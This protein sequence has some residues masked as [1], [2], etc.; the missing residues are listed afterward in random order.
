MVKKKNVQNKKTRTETKVEKNKFDIINYKKNYKKL[1]IISIIIFLVAIISIVQTVREESTPIYRD[2]TLKGGLSAIINVD[3]QISVADL[4]D[5]LSTNFKDN[6]FSISELYDE[7]KREGFIIDTD[8]SEEDLM[9]FLSNYFK[10]EFISGDNYS[11]N[12]ISP[13]LSNSFFMQSVYILMISF[14]IMSFV[15]FLYFREFV[16]SEA[17]VLSAI[18]DIIVT[19]GVLDFLNFKISVAGIGALLMLVGYSIDTD[20]LLTNRLV[21]EKGDN[22]FEKAFDAFK[23][24]SIMSATTLIAGVSA[25]FL[26]NSNIIYEISL[27][28]VVGLLVDYVSTWIQ[29]TGILLWWITARDK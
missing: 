19:I 28:L 24:G 1:I 22:Y 6:T 3:T 8:A 11:S 25:L 20:V 18:F 5:V 7:G 13:T 26:T 12:F 10:V 17:V 29:N 16:P 4:E 9:S 2:V 27:I 23:T 15:I 21:K 14:C